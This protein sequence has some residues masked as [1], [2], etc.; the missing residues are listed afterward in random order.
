MKQTSSGHNPWPPGASREEE[1]RG[2]LQRL[3]RMTTQVM[4]RKLFEKSPSRAK[5]THRKPTD[6]K[7]K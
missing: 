4:A 7:T 6:T 5:P 2:I 3:L 1:V